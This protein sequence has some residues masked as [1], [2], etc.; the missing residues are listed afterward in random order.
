MTYSAERKTCVH[1]NVINLRFSESRMLA[2]VDNKALQHN[3][4]VLNPKLLVT[5]HETK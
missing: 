2:K 1:S 4:D 5:K 3:F